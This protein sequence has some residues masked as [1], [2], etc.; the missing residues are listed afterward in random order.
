MLYDVPSS[1]NIA[2]FG[3]YE[4]SVRLPENAKVDDFS[5]LFSFVVNSLG[6]SHLFL[7]IVTAS[8]V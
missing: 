5:S 3:G 8:V 4:A 2:F 6:M 7:Q 1:F